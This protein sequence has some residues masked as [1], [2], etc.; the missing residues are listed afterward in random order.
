MSYLAA[1][2]KLANVIYKQPKV[3]YLNYIRSAQWE[4]TRNEHL[5][6]CDYLC[7][8]CRQRRAIQVHHWSYA[9][10]GY[11]HP[12]DLCAVCVRCHHLIHCSVLPV[13]ANE[14]E[15]PLPGIIEEKSAS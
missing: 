13:G 9:R 8:L 6:R 4:R 14:N 7:E 15:P 2:K 11:E 10:L 5:F 1:I 12:L 3:R